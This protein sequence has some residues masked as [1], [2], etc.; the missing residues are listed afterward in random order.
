MTE[1]TEYERTAAERAELLAWWAAER[2]RRGGTVAPEP[3]ESRAAGLVG[4]LVALVV[5]LAA[6][7]VAWR[8]V[9]SFGWVYLRP[10]LDWFSGH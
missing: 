8:L 1:P 6:L 2:R 7:Y 9:D 3:A 4:R 10:L 5:I